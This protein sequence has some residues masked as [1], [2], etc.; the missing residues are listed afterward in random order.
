MTDAPQEPSYP[1]LPAPGSGPVAQPMTGQPQPGMP[2]PVIMNMNP[3]G[4]P[5]MQP[6][7]QP[8]MMQPG[9]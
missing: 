6:M 4:Q 3:N 1:N 5:P 8:M 7:Q 9:Q 2:Q